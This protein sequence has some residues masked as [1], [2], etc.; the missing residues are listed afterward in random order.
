MLLLVFS[1]KCLTR[2]LGFLGC[3]TRI[4][5]VYFC[6]NIIYA[7]SLLEECWK[8][9]HFLRWNFLQKLWIWKHS[10]LICVRLTDYFAGCI[11]QDKGFTEK[12][13]SSAMQLQDKIPFN[14]W[15]C[16]NNSLYHIWPLWECNLKDSTSIYIQIREHLG[17]FDF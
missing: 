5:K 14:F 6:F 9:R 15:N 7:K 11:G 4:M 12:R 16:K 13:D 3:S 17:N 1:Q 8:L 2:I 10:K